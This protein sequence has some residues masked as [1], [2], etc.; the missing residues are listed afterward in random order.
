M[1]MVNPAPPGAAG[2]F[3]PVGA[4]ADI[5]SAADSA[6]LAAVRRVLTMGPDIP[7][8][9]RLTRLAADLLA[10]P[11]SQVSLLA[12]E[13]YVASLHGADLTAAAQATPV[14]D[15]LCAITLEQRATVIINDT[16][17]DSRAAALPPVTDGGVRAYLGV[18]LLDAAGHALG[19]LCVYDQHERS[20]TAKDVGVLGE[21][22]SSV[23]A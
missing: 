13:Q 2:P 17:A 9:N 12:E 6:R 21:L 18:P 16:T 11:F 8:L 3:G 19:A 5:D 22:A 15:S 7:G 20:W 1:S 4:D 10:A 23:V 14:A